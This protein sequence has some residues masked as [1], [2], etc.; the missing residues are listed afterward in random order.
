MATDL[1]TFDQSGGLMILPPK[2]IGWAGGLPAPAG[3][4]V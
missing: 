4:F 1:A 2:L 3:A